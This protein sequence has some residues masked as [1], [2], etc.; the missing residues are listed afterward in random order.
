MDQAISVYRPMMRIRKWYCFL[1]VY[2]LQI[3]VYNGW[4]PNRRLDPKKWSFLEFPRN[5]V[6]TYLSVYKT[7]R[8]D[9]KMNALY[10]VRSFAQR[11]N[12]NIRYDGIG[13]IPGRG[14]TRTRC[15]VCANHTFYQ[16]NKCGVKLHTKCFSA[17]HGDRN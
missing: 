10:Q 12:D 2:I 15:G 5:I 16:C 7:N 14:E 4:K 6:T 3:S 9:G 1:F 8:R 13:H 17:F 11:V